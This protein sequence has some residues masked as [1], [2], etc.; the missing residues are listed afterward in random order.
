MKGVGAKTAESL[1]RS[2]RAFLSGKIEVLNKPALPDPRLKIYLDFEDDPLQELIYLCGVWTEPALDG[3]NYHGLFGVDEAGEAQL[4]L[5]LQRFCEGIVHEDYG[6]FHYSPYEKIKIKALEAKYGV[7]PK[8]ALELFKSRMIDLHTVTKH[9]VA[10]PVSGYSIKQ[11]GAFVGHQYSVEDPG[12]AQSIAWFEE[13]Q[14]D[15]TKTGILDKILTYNREDCLALRSVYH[16][17]SQF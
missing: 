14:H 10:V 13:F 2:A 17:L 3:R 7:S 15:P 12:G 11:I 6:V 8:E 1:L 4:W 9:S 5:D 16:W